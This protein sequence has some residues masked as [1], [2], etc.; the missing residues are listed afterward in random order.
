MVI[1]T[2]A[3]MARYAGLH[4]RFAEAF[5]FLR[6]C[7]EA[8]PPEGRVELD[9]ERLFATV[10]RYTTKPAA[11]GLLEA[12]RKYI[13][14][15]FIVAGEEW[16]GYAPLAATAEDAPFRA[17]DDIGF[18]RGEAGFTRLSQGMFAVFFPEDAHMPGRHVAAPTEVVKVVVKVL[19]EAPV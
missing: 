13:D 6:R 12:H 16:M 7:A 4:P 1:G 9:G 2:L 11:E 15:Q 10:Q 14:I 18:L 19:A 17:A 5:G 3:E 8:P